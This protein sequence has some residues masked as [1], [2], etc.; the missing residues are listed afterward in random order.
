VAQY[1][2]SRYSLGVD[3][4]TPNVHAT[5]T[6]K[7]SPSN[8]KDVYLVPLTRSHAKKLQEQVNSFQ[9]DCTFMTSKNVIL[10][11]CFTL[12]VLRCTHVEKS[13]IRPPN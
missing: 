8:I 5:S 3:D 12:V 13:W 6:V 1:P 11:T 9:T 7:H 2:T 10:P 4:D